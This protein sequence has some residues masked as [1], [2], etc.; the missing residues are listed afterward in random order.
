MIDRQLAG[1]SS[2]TPF[3]SIKDSYNKKVTFDTQDGV[4]DKIERLT[5]MM[6]KQATRDNRINKQF[7]PQ[8][9]QSERRGQSRNIYDKF[10]YDRGSH[11]NR[12]KSNSSDRRIQYR[13]NRGRPRYEHNY[14]KFYRGGNFRGNM[15]TYHTF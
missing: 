15:R 9:Y 8:I 4:E 10:N 2:S 5:V 12:Y 14:S 7:K 6:G 11:H 3:M 13:Q 1:Q